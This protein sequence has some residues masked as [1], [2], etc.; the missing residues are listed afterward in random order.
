[1]ELFGEDPVHV[2]GRHRRGGALQL[3]QGL[4]VGPGELRR[5]RR[6][7]D[8]Q[9]LAE[10]HRAAL[11]LAEHGEQLLSALGRHLGGDLLAVASG[12]ALTPPADRATGDTEREAGQLRGALDAAAGDF[13]HESILY[14]PFA[15]CTFRSSHPGVTCADGSWSP[16]GQT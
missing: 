3:G 15:D 9:R 14:C 12:E 10:L 8:A 11:E 5:D 1:P 2:A 16:G 6:L 7:E 13:T 4:A